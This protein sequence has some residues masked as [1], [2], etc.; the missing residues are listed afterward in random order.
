MVHEDQGKLVQVVAA[1]DGLLAP[2]S[3][4]VLREENRPAAGAEPAK[5]TIPIVDLSLLAKP[6]GVEEAA[7]LRSALQSWGLFVV[8]GHGM[9]KEFLDE[10]LD[11]TRKFFHLPLEEKQRCSNV[12]GGA[13]FQNEGYGTDRIDS[14]EQIL[15]WC[16]RLWLQ[17][18]PEDERRLEFWPQSLRHSIYTIYLS[19]FFLLLLYFGEDNF[20]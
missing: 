18:Q 9:P 14:D 4:Y 3:R 12:I 1:E 13:M 5:L 16:D 19:I 10:I 6:N 17:L 7:K 15:D 2:P 8:T 11:A 20:H